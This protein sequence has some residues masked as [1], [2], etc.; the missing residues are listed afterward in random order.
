V[1]SA[2]TLRYEVEIDGR[3]RQ[4]SI[5]RARGRFM[6]TVDGRERMVDAARVD[7]HTWSLLVQED[8]QRV[9]SHEVSITPEPASD[10]FAV[11]V[12]LTPM[13]VS[14]NSRRRWGRK[15]QGGE[16]GAGPQRVV[17]SMSG[18][19]VRVLVQRGEAVRAR[20]PLVVIEAM[21][22]ENEL[23]AARGGTVAD[24]KVRD[25]QSVDAGA[26]LVVIV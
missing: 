17:A 21:K 1:W 9:S 23:S 7:A 6:A 18:K 12:G 2:D 19:V 14:L 25:G 15:D 10:R 20:Q 24:I 13:T 26:L 5:Q 4:V 11:Q 16:P 3:L 22:M 8:G